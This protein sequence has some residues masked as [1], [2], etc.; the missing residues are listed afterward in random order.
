M[1]LPITLTK[2]TIRHLLAVIWSLF[3]MTY[4]FY[5][6]VCPVPA[7]NVRIVD[8]ILGVILGTVISTIISFYLGSSLSSSDKTDI[9]N[10]KYLNQ[11]GSPKEDI[12]DANYICLL[13]QMELKL[14][15]G[16]IQLK[17]LTEKQ[18]Q[19][20]NRTTKAQKT[21]LLAIDFIEKV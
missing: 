13:L 6:T 3:A 20:F 19:I 12:V 17:D 5:V 10:L 11:Y 1:Q 4:I 9:L 16:I 14:R 15:K 18:I 2:N 21:N 8:T 7:S